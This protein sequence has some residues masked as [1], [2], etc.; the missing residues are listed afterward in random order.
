M[1]QTARRL[2]LPPRR[3]SRSRNARERDAIYVED[4]LPELQRRALAAATAAAAPLAAAR[5][6][7]AAASIPPDVAAAAAASV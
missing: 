1:A 7:A 4:E 3:R 6:A 5:A 2:R